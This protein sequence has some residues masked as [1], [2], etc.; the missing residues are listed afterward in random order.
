MNKLYNEKT[1]FIMEVTNNCSS[2]ALNRIEQIKEFALEANY[3]KIGIAHC[4]TFYREAEIIQKYLEKDF[5]VFCV[6]CKYG[7]LRKKDLLN[8][9]SFGV[10]CNPAGQAKFLNDKKTDLNISLGLCVGHDMI[11]NIESK[12]LVTTLYSKDFTNNNNMDVAVSKISNK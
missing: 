4:I 9:N 2:M 10:L 11:F 6:D 7:R 12:A 1:K 3:E 5:Q 8:D